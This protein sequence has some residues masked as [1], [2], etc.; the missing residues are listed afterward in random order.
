M[1][2]SPDGQTIYL[3]GYG[4]AAETAVQASNTR[5]IGT[6]P[7]SQPCC[8]AVSPD[9]STLYV[10]AGSYLGMA[11]TVVDTATLQVTQSVPLASISVLFGLAISPD[12][13]QLYLPAQVKFHEATNNLLLV[14]DTHNFEVLDA[15]AF[16]PTG[17]LF[18]PNLN[19]AYAYLTVGG[20]SGFM[21]IVGSAGATQGCDCAQVT[22][23]SGL[24]PGNRRCYASE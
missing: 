14:A 24:A 19:A 23:R 11:V 18:V 1:T 15:L 13:S 12:G 22:V 2:V 3:S 9:S 5:L 20:G 17:Q 16:Q 8:A 21:T 4:Y 6:V 7:L 10:V